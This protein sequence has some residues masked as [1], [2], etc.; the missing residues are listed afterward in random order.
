MAPADER[1][2]VEQANDA[3]SDEDEGDLGLDGHRDGERR[4]RQCPLEPVLHAEL[5]QPV[6]RM[7]DQRDDG[8]ADAVEDRRHG[9]ETFEPNKQRAERRDDDEVR[10]DKGPAAGPGAPEPTTDVR[11]PDPDLDRQRPRERLTHGDA[12]AH[13]LLREPLLLTHQ[14]ALH[15]ADKSNG[16]AEPEYTEAQVVPDEITNG[17]A[18]GRLLRWHRAAPCRKLSRSVTL[19]GRCINQ[20]RHAVA[21]V[22][23]EFA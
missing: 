3:A 16:T 7:Q 23:D 15:L 19:D 5:G 17:N 14:L 21:D 10:Q 1:A 9:R 4:R 12:L 20:Y 2:V 22:T 6:A 11:D 13:L 8:W 18:M